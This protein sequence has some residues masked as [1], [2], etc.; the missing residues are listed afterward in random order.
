MVST[1][2]PAGTPTAEV[3]NPDEPLVVVLPDGAVLS[4]STLAEV[5]D[6]LIPGYAAT[7]EDCEASAFAAREEFAAAFATR[8]AEM[9]AAAVAGDLP[10][11]A[12]LGGEPVSASQVPWVLVTTQYAPHTDV[13]VPARSV[14][15]I[16]PTTEL[17]LL[18]SLHATGE[19]TVS[20]MVEGEN[21]FA[22]ST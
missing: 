4:A 18:E 17:T 2:F 10:E 3:A 21:R 9:F 8:R 22:A 16:D 13:A 15:W 6:A 12:L 1:L 5:L 20:V 7:A 14:E 11:D 19:I